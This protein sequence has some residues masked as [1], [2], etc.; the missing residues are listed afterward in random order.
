MTTMPRGLRAAGPLWRIATPLVALDP[1]IGQSIGELKVD[2]LPLTEI[3]KYRKQASALVD[4]VGF[5]Q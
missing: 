5:D 2:P 3:A 4:K 1:I